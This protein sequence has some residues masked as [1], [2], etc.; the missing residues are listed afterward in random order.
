MDTTA[1]S[2]RVCVR[3]DEST[4]ALIGRAT[5]LETFAGVLAGADILAHCEAQ[6]APEFYADWLRRCP[7]FLWLAES[8]VGRAPIGYIGL[9]EPDLPVPDRSTSDVELKRIYVLSRFHGTGVGP[10]LMEQALLLARQA[11]KERLLLGVY[12]ENERALAFYR[13]NGFT[14]VAR[15]RFTVGGHGYEDTVFARAV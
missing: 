4:L 7:G 14:A 8:N 5:F 15:R 1:Y 2:L 3:G 13:R 6:H 11:K 9:D 12:A 10:A